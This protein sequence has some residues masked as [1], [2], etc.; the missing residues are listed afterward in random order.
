MPLLK[1]I[2]IFIFKLENPQKES[3]QKDDSAYQYA[4]QNDS[5]SKRF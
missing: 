4:I 3:W 1:K 2:G 5:A